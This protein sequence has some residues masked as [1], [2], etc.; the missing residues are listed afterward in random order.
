MPVKVVD[1]DLA[2]VVKSCMVP[3][4]GFP[5]EH[6][7]WNVPGA[8]PRYV[9]Y[10]GNP[11]GEDQL[12]GMSL[13]PSVPCEQSFASL[14]P[15]DAKYLAPSGFAGV[16]DLASDDA[17]SVLI[18][19]NNRV[20]RLFHT[21]GRAYFDLEVTPVLY[22][23]LK[24]PF[25]AITANNLSLLALSLSEYSDPSNQRLLVFRKA[26]RTWHRLPS[27]SQQF[28]W[29]RSFGRFLA[30]ASAQERSAKVPESPGR[31]EWRN[32]SAP[33][34]PNLAARFANSSAVFLGRL[35]LYDVDS[36]QTYTI[37]TNQGDS[38]VLLVE[39]DIV[40]YRVSD[41][42]Y[43]AAI[44]KTGLGEAK[45]LAASDVI[46]DAHWAFIKR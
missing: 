27:F 8:G 40:Y 16:A 18:D 32:K 46:R 29:T 31:A 28:S 5:M 3:A 9:E 42:L 30:V 36:G 22:E 6:W 10:V 35:Y 13:D 41:R 39:N 43:S 7:I 14:S 34:G 23:D 33:T 12:R 25:G 15:T 44:T 19:S 26:D 38:E 24:R 1:L 2:A 21:I 17:M 20:N 4:V 37:V 45:L 11:G